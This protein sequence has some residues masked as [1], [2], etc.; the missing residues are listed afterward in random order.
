MYYN[1]Y[2]NYTILVKSLRAKRNK[3]IS[4]LKFFLA[5]KFNVVNLKRHTLLFIFQEDTNLLFCFTFLPV[6]LKRRSFSRN[7]TYH[8]FFI[9]RSFS[10]SSPICNPDTIR[11]QE[12]PLDCFLSVCQAFQKNKLHSFI[13]INNL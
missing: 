6:M 13:N 5:L 1:N 8:C 2:K 10:L 3:T 12:N 11:R 4:I 9:V 7:S